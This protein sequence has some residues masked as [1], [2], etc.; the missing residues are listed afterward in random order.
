MHEALAPRTVPIPLRRSV[1]GG[2]PL[3]WLAGVGAAFVLAQLLLVVPGSGM[4]W[5]ESVYTSQVSGHAPAAFFSAPRARGISFLAAPVAAFTPSVTALRVYLALLSGAGLS[6]SLWVWRDLLPARVLATAG[7]LFASLWITLYYG[8]SVMPNL[9]SAF[10]ALAA[11]G[12]FVRLARGAGDRRAG[13][14]LVLSVAVVALMRPPDGLWLGLALG[15]AA[16]CVRRWRRPGLLALLAAGFALGS[17][18]W[19]VEAYVRYGGL[20]ARLHRASEI[21]GGMGWHMA[22]DDQVRSLAGRTLCRPCDIP[23]QHPATAL[24][25]FALP[26]LA[27][28][29]ILVTP[30]GRRR[31]TAVV[32]AVTAAIVAVPYLFL[33]DYAAPRFLLPSYALLALPVARS[34]WWLATDRHGRLR[35]AATSL[36]ALALAGHLAVQYAVLANNTAEVRASHRDFTRAAA[37]L[38]QLGVRPPCVISGDHSVQLSFYT[39]CSSRQTGGPDASITAAGVRAAT[40]SSAVTVVVPPGG[41]PHPVAGEWRREPLAPDSSASRFHGYTV[42]LP[43]SVRSSGSAQGGSP[44]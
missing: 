38:H 30:W 27:V 8:P 15:A 42:Y 12:F 11:T 33:I 7:A 25:W 17:A 14:G 22:V 35:T 20:T 36:V 4:G 2:R 5:D 16:L 40:R 26:L 23:W 39:R 24:W 31:A 18:E 10:G 44:R 32:P 13:A 34:L 9:W 28:A 29:G 37:R 41:R 19:I 1:P 3:P 6:A 43:S 21:Q